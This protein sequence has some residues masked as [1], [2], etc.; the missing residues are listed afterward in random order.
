MFIKLL[1]PGDVTGLKEYLVNHLLRDQGNQKEGQTAHLGCYL[2]RAGK[3][4]SIHIKSLP[5]ENFGGEALRYRAS[6]L[7]EIPLDSRVEGHN[8]YSFKG[9][10]GIP[11]SR[12]LQ[13]GKPK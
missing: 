6:F 4:E 2:E 8:G 12:K 7:G 5:A 3:N 13:T 9:W 1:V 10:K 11:V